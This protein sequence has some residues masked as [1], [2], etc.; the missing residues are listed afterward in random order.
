MERF[1]DSAASSGYF[2]K[3]DNLH[4]S[5]VRTCVVRQTSSKS[6]SLNHFEDCLLASEMEKVKQTLKKMCNFCFQP[7]LS[8][9]HLTKRHM[10]ICCEL[11]N[12]IFIINS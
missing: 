5:A 1:T 2:E 7:H 11:N 4:S 6:Q 9:L 10:E 12:L 8:T 3:I